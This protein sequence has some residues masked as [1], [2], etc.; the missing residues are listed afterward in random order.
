MTLAVLLGASTIVAASP[1]VAADEPVPAFSVDVTTSPRT[2]PGGTWVRASVTVTAR[3]AD[4]YP[5]ALVSVAMSWDTTRLSVGTGTEHGVDGCL[6]VMDPVAMESAVPP[7]PGD[8]CVLEVPRDPLTPAVFTYWFQL[9]GVPPALPV[10]TAQ[11]TGGYLQ[12]VEL[13]SRVDFD[14]AD[15]TSD[16]DYVELAPR[17]PARARRSPRPR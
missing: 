16:E 15:L 14:A 17:R 1:A 6:V 11:V 2:A 4:V 9:L 12:D 10:V 8:E 13:F 7:G 5:D 3:D